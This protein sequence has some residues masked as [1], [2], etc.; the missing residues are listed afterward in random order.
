MKY[1]FAS[2]RDINKE[3]HEMG[4]HLESPAECPQHGGSEC[5]PSL[6]EGRGSGWGGCAGFD[7]HLQWGRRQGW[8]WVLER[9]TFSLLGGED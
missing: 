4:V 9:L 2:A 7:P 6:L 8:L 1:L 5:Q 3:A